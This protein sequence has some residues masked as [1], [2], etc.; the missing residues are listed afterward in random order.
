MRPHINLSKIAIFLVSL[1]LFILALTLMQDGA[2]TLAPLVRDYVGET[3]PIHSLGFGWLGAYIL[4][5]G[6]PIAAAA[7]AFF[8]AGAIDQ[9][10]TFTMITGSRFGASLAIFFLGF[11]YVLRGR[12]RA[13]S[14]S[15]GLLSLAIT[16]TTH[17]VGL[18]IGLWLLRAG[19]L[20]TIQASTQGSSGLIFNSFFERLVYPLARGLV[21]PFPQWVAFFIGLCLIIA[22]FSL[23]DRALPQV[24]LKE[25]HIAH[26]AHLVYHPWVMLA[27]GAAVTIL[28]MS[29][30][31]SLG[32]LVP[33]SDRGYIRRENVIP[34][35][36]GANVTT[37]IDT[38]LAAMLLNN[39]QAFTI[40]LVEM[41]SIALVSILIMIT[42]YRPYERAMLNFVTWASDTN[43]NLALFTFAIIGIPFLLIIL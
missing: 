39:P 42:C 2:R 13:A 9:W 20:N 6:S 29:V 11:I 7:L 10:S 40:V 36:L 17:I 33:L 3:E 21:A 25:S 43:R 16:G 8:D 5:S 41:A 18:G 38:L 37:F 28:S 35:I 14:L 24:A 32:I 34:Y 22:S 23:F 31:I 15:M 1:F 19:W 12:N 4:M 26:V 30:T 27:L